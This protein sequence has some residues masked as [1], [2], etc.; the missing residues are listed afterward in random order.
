MDGYLCRIHIFPGVIVGNLTRY[1][2]YFIT[3]ST[4]IVIVTETKQTLRH[5][6]QDISNLAGVITETD[7]QTSN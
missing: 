6:D 3:T 4:Y 1:V 2:P 5:S 7:T